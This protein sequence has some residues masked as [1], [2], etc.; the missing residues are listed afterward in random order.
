MA[1]DQFIA[2]DLNHYTYGEI[3]EAFK[4]YIKGTFSADFDKVIYKLD[5]VI[6]AKVMKC[7]AVEKIRL[8][9]N[10]D[11]QVRRNVLL[12]K[13]RDNQPTEEEKY[14]IVIEGVKDA[15]EN[16][17]Q[18]GKMDFG[19]IYLYDF[20]YERGLLPKDKETKQAVFKVAK[21]NIWKKRELAITKH[22]KAM[23]N[24][25]NKDGSHTQTVI[26]ECYR[27]SIGRYFDQFAKYEQMLKQIEDAN[28]NYKEV[29][30]TG[31]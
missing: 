1:V 24:I 23:W 19:R 5:C 13:E 31:D 26:N 30:G 9:R 27:L 7:Y 15:Y 28:R 17:K 29:N 2:E 25:V 6:L 22:E 14:N 4:M 16:Y 8:M 11:E 10:Y 18:T 21:E 3:K 12:L 20:L